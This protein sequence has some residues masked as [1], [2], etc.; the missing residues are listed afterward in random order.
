MATAITTTA[1][2]TRWPYLASTA[3]ISDAVLEA[4]IA[5][6]DEGLNVRGRALL[7]RREEAVTHYAA[8][9]ATLT[10]EA[11]N[12]GGMASGPIAA[13][14]FLHRSRSRSIAASSS[15]TDP[16]SA[17]LE[18]TVPGRA[19]LTLLRATLQTPRLIQ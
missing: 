19:L 9:K 15:T 8:H 13:D 12:S 2:R 5:E 10:I 16:M 6:A 14:S 1:V 4:L 18:Q 17:D 11:G 3:T 7:I